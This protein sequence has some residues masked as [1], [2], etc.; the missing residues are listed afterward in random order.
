MR[1]DPIEVNKYAYVVTASSNLG[2]DR[3]KISHSQQ[4][5]EQVLSRIMTLQSIQELSHVSS[6]L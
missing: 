2:P 5:F 3:A 6:S 1:V 4:V